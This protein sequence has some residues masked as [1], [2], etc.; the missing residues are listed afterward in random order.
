[1]VFACAHPGAAGTPAQ[2]T[3]G[4][5]SGGIPL[6]RAHGQ[7]DHDQHHG[8]YV[9]DMR[10]HDRKFPLGRPPARLNPDL[11]LYLGLESPIPT[12]A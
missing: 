7:D 6:L 4:T 12:D 9:A 11:A 10:T 5:S 3:S 1:M 2:S 8:I